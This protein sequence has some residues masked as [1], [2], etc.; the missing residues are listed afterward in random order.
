MLMLLRPF[1]CLL[2][3]ALSAAWGVAQA[4]DG[5]LQLPRGDGLKFLF[6]NRDRADP[7]IPGRRE[8]SGPEE[9]ALGLVHPEVHRENFIHAPPRHRVADQDRASGHAVPLVVLGLDKGLHR[10]ARGLVRRPHLHVPP[11]FWRPVAPVFRLRDRA[12]SPTRRPR[13]RSGDVQGS[14]GRFPMKRGSPA[15]TIR[16]GA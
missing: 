13:A 9:H 3:I 12:A 1:C 15:R 4:A 8:E 11:T 7:A 6:R 2:L 5:P 14:R 10:R 16:S